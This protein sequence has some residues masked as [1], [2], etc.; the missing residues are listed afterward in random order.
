MSTGNFINQ[1]ITVPQ[2]KVSL[3]E[4][5]KKIIAKVK[6]FFNREVDP[7]TFEINPKYLDKVR[8]GHSIRVESARAHIYIN[9]MNIR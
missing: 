4:T 8:N 9:N 6:G 2:P 3:N 5:I 1:N 7:L